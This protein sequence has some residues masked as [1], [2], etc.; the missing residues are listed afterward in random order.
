MT[1]QELVDALNA[2]FA[3]TGYSFS[4]T[5]GPKYTRVVKTQG[6]SSSVYCFTDEAG[7]IYKPE[8]WKRPAKGIR[9]TLA[10]LDI[11]RADLHGAWLY[12]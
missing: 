11:N 6:P 2:K 10:T 5:A 9:G 12:R 3:A 7:N 4:V 1:T 8:G